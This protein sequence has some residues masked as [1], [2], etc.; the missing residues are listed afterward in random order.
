MLSA[1]GLKDQ[2]VSEDADL[3]TQIATG[4]IGDPVAELYRR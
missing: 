1:A 3:I 4:D 2:S